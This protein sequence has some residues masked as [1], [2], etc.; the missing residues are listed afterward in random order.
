MKTVR[1]AKQIFGR[2]LERQWSR[3]HGVI[4]WPAKP[5]S[6]DFELSCRQSNQSTPKQMAPKL[7]NN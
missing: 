5:G 4:N 6:A 7:D 1:C 2:T 3:G